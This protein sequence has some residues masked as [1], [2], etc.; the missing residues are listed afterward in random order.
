[1]PAFGVMG[2]AVARANFSPHFEASAIGNQDV[3]VHVAKR[4][5][6]RG[7]DL[8]RKSDHCFLPASL[9]RHIPIKNNTS[10]FVC[11]PDRTESLTL[12]S[13]EHGNNFNLATTVL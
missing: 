4:F 8:T 12:R 7:A 13:D 11:L 10:K 6:Y 2:L 9:D 1:V 5:R 3:A